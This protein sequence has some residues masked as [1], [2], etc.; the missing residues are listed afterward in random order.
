MGYELLLL[1]RDTDP[2]K[3]MIGGMSEELYRTVFENAVEGLYRTTPEG[4]FLSANQAMARICGYDSPQAL[5]SALSNLPGQL[6]VDP[7]DQT[8]FLTRLRTSGRVS[9]F[10]CRF[11]RKDGAVRWA[12]VHARAVADETGEFIAIEG[13]FEDVTE[14]KA[15]ESA[16]QREL[17]QGREERVRAERLLAESH[18]L[19]QTAVDTMPDALFYKDEIGVYRL[20]NRAFAQLFGRQPEQILGMAEAEL[21]PPDAGRRR[22]EAALSGD[23]VQTGDAA[24]AV[25]RSQTTLIGADGR[26]REVLVCQAA[27]RD[28]DGRL[29]GIV[30]SVVDITERVAMEAALRQ[31]EESYRELFNEALDGIFQSIPGGPFTRVNPAL[32]RML[33]YDSPAQLGDHVADMAGDLFV[34]QGTRWEFMRELL[35]AGRVEA[36]EAPIRRRDGSVFWASISARTVWSRE[37]EAELIEGLMRDVTEQHRE[38]AELSRRASHD[39]LTGLANRHSFQETFGRMLDQARRS[40]MNLAVLYIDLDGFKAVND[41]YGHQAGDELLR[42]IAGRIRSRL[43][44]TDLAARLGGDEFAVVLWDVSGLSDVEPVGRSLIR[45][46]SRPV[47]LGDGMVGR[48]GASIGASL[49]PEHGQETATLLEQADQAMYAVKQAGKNDFALAGTPVA[50]VASGPRV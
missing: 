41:Q 6:Y 22:A 46:L 13:I 9:G 38:V 14:R 48:V 23:T 39:E 7:A 42:Q 1:A 36:F 12:A 20:V 40:G 43:R 2:E 16:L 18:R 11:R 25:R 32:A 10:E 15:R 34:D 45:S 30:G 29:T 49:F 27:V 31:A 17:K 19:L 35:D 28:G 24:A 4:R 26:L 50:P 8:D 3:G 37:G 21:W 44:T 33:G 47:H 5:M